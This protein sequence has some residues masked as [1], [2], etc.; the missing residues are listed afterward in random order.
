MLTGV[1]C[2]RELPSSKGDAKSMGREALMPRVVCRKIEEEE[3][4]E[5][6]RRRG[7]ARSRGTERCSILVVTTMMM[8]TGVKCLWR[9]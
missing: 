1:S 8:D 2:R 3:E 4:V 9:E 7:A 6:S 5:G